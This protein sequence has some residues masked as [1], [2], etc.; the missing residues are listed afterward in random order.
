MKLADIHPEDIKASIRKQ[1]GTIRNFELSK[2]LPRGSVHEV[3]RRRRWAR[4]ERAI[5]SVISASPSEKTDSSRE[6]ETHRL[7]AEAR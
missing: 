5:E 3:L 7:S 6:T 4:I 1:F 2:G